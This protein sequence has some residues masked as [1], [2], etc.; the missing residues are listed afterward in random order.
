[1][2]DLELTEPEQITLSQSNTVDLELTQDTLQIELTSPAPIELNLT[3]QINELTIELANGTGGTPI[4][5]CVSNG[6]ISSPRVVEFAVN[7]NIQHW[8]GS[9]P[10]GIS[11][12][13]AAGANE[14]VD[15]ICQGLLVVPGGIFTPGTQY[16]AGPNGTLVSTP[17]TSGTLFMVAVA[18]SATQ[19]IVNIAEGVEL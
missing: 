14:T 3:E 15:V 10:I 1:M 2:I 17:P 8:T 9:R 7:G 13:S 4:L 16:F 18:K 19:L 11:Q 5:E 12:T 6:P